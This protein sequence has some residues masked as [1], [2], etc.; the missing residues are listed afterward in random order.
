[1]RRCRVLQLPVVL[2]LPFVLLRVCGSVI[3]AADPEVPAGVVFDKEIEYANPDGQHLQLNLA[4]PKAELRLAEKTHHS[5]DIDF[6]LVVH[7]GSIEDLW[8]DV[9]RAFQRL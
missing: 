4:R 3:R 5:S 6:D 7:N 8:N 9:S 1:M 2:F